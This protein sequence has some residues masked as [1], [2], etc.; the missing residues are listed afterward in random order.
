MRPILAVPLAL[1]ILAAGWWF[2]EDP[3][4]MGPVFDFLDEQIQSSEEAPPLVGMQSDERWLVVVVD[5]PNFPENSFRN[6]EKAEVILSG[7]NGADDYIDQA[8]AGTSS[9]SVTVVP[10]VYHAQEHDSY[11]GR[12]DGDFRDA[13]VEGSHGPADLVE[14][15][16]K[17]SLDGVNL[18]EFDLNGDGW[19]DRFLVMHTAD[20]QENSGGKG[21]IWS[22]FGPL[23]EPVTIGEHKFDHF[24]ISGFDSGLGTVVHEMLHQM[25]ALDLYDVHGHG[26]GEDWNGLGDWDVMASGNWNGAGGNYPALPTLGTLD[27]IDVKRSVEVSF[28]DGESH[29][30]NFSL[31][32]LSTGGS[33]LEIPISPSERVWMAYRADSGFDRHLP[34][35][36][37][38]VTVQ[39]D[40]VGDPS[41]NLVNTDAD[42]PYLYV[43]EADGDEGLLSGT[44]EGE[45]SDVFQEGEKFGSEGVLIYDHHGRLVPW[46]VTVV[47]VEEASIV[48][49]IDYNHNID[50][51]IVPPHQPIQVLPGEEVSINTESIDCELTSHSLF[52]SDG[53]GLTIDDSEQD[54]WILT[55]DSDGTSNTA[56]RINGSV[57]CGESTRFLEI[58]FHI[59]GLRLV[60][61]VFESG[62]A[63]SDPS[64]VTVPLQFEGDGSQ[65]WDIRIEGPLERIATT[66]ATANLA[67]GYD[68]NLSIDPSGLLVPGMVAKGSI[69]LR[70][71]QGMEQTAEVIL[72]AEHFEGTSRLTGFLSNP[73]N[74]ILVM[75]GMLALSVLLGS[76]DKRS[77]ITKVREAGA[78]KARSMTSREEIEPDVFAQESDSPTIESSQTNN[79]LTPGSF[80]MTDPNAIPDIE[81][82]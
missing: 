73:S 17:N 41:Q 60:S 48:V 80:A 23:P 37:L 78:A 44:D 34:G 26:T 43:L 64:I 65:N 11:W 75:S 3:T 32:P 5:F 28:L 63:V 74:I 46:V 29:Q 54:K 57:T 25:G 33:G 31:T 58:P 47:D 42:V 68:I 15:V 40:A 22:H 67:D 21:R 56:G 1:M 36:G 55:W 51:P 69:V 71:S 8:S 18:S 76:F 27:L 9:L 7:S 50:L 12:D 61:P 62:I 77:P 59:I 6:V 52:S 72:T 45:A 66:E 79:P 81:D 2:S 49:N 14:S 38:L 16:I 13:G 10:A 20:T 35:H 19:V 53:R 4:R 39:D 70:D 82:Y 24:T 30:Q